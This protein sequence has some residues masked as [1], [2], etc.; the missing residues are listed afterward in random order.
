VKTWCSDESAVKLFNDVV[1]I[2]DIGHAQQAKLLGNILGRST[3]LI[4]T[5]CL[6]AC[7]CQSGREVRHEILLDDGNPVPATC[8]E[9]HSVVV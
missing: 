5:E 2:S 8:P 4:P 7:G 1:L 9:K 6:G 3:T